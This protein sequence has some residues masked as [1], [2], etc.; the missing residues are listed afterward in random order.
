MASVQELDEDELLNSAVN[1][2][3]FADDADED[4]LLGGG[5]VVSRTTTFE[6]ET[7][8]EPESAQPAS[9][10]EASKGGTSND[11]FIEHEL[12]YEEDEEEREERT[13]KFTSERVVSTVETSTI[14]SDAAAAQSETDSA[15]TQ[16]NANGAGPRPGRGRGGGHRGRGRGNRGGPQGF[17]PRGPYNQGVCIPPPPL[18]GPG[19]NPAQ[20][21]AGG[22]ILVN[23]KF[24][25]SGPPQMPLV[26]LQLEGQPSQVMMPP[27]GHLGPPSVLP[28]LMAGPAG[29]IIPRLPNGIPLIPLPSNHGV[30]GFGPPMSGPPPGLPPHL[31]AGGFNPNRPPPVNG[32]QLPQWD[33]AVAAFLNQS[34]VPSDSVDERRHNRHR[35]SSYSSYSSS[36]SGSYS[37]S[38]RSRSHSR[39][40]SPRRR[41]HSSRSR[42]YRSRDG[43]EGR[44]DRAAGGRDGRDQGSWRGRGGRGRGGRRDDRRDDYRRRDREDNRE[45]TIEHAK[46]IGLDQDYLKRLEE[47]K[48]RR[49]EIVRMKEQRRY[50][51][52][53]DEPRDRQDRQAG[54]SKSRHPQ[55]QQPNAQERN[56]EQE[57]ERDRDKERRPHVTASAEKKK[58][59]LCVTISNLKQLPTAKNRIEALAKDLGDIKVSVASFLKINFCLDN[60]FGLFYIFLR[61]F[62]SS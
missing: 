11:T 55:Q 6:F 32:A 36:Y 50:G 35:S 48:R 38:S 20:F 46:A 1:P 24:R 13:G 29:P 15:Q 59:Y 22:K 62:I 31:A 43:R 7:E 2:A 12:D 19:P 54:D 47:Q 16:S 41:R 18:L 23:P 10:P 61:K 14:N 45:Q 44:D 39:S 53:K 37:D 8:P 57:Q 58:A 40:R 28:N 42:R 25:G 27:M 5:G 3:I 17:Y 30:A 34:S 21:G 49:E 56:R 52:T 26:R 4:L 51:D 60:I 33:Q 9:L